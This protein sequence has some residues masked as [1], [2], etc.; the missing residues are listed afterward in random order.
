MMVRLLVVACAALIYVGQAGATTFYVSPQGDDSAAGTSPATAWKTVSK[1]NNTSLKAGDQVLFQGGASF[2]GPLVP[3]GTGK[4][5]KPTVYGSYG[6]GKATIESTANNVVFFHAASWVTV[7]NLRL[8]TLGTDDHVVVSDP[9]TTS[10]YITLKND[11]ITNTAAFG[12]NS[13][14]LTDHDWT[15]QGNTVSNTGETGITFRGSGFDVI[16]NIVQNT[17]R[18][19][20]EASHGVYAKGPNAQVIGNV[21]NGFATSGVSIRY[22]NAVVQGNAIGGGLMGIGQFQ[23]DGV[24][25]GGVSTIAYNTIGD[26]SLCGIYLDGSSLES[27]DIVDNTID[28]TAGNGINFRPVKALTFANNIV[29]GHFSDY[30]AIIRKPAGAYYEHNNLWFPATGAAFQWQGNAQTFAQYHSASTQGKGDLTAD[31]DL[32]GSLALLAGSP[33][34]DAGSVLP[35]LGYKHS[36]NGTAFSYCGAAPDMGAVERK[37]RLRK[38]SSAPKPGGAPARSA[39]GRRR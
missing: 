10:A 21:I 31:P 13:P 37:A 24:T 4:Q 11:L 19:P 14:S 9:A 33:A 16:G 35:S 8:T 20:S 5:G 7:Q 18:S 30:A 17:G 23:D 34:I 28:T 36:C 15:I 25:A 38:K 22:Q 29:T 1:V 12:I 26:V 39:R 27:F 2:E 3:W 32:D 6:T